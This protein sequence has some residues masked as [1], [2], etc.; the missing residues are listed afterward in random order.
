M[1]S[2]HPLLRKLQFLESDLTWGVFLVSFDEEDT[3]RSDL[4]PKTDEEE[5]Q[6]RPVS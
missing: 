3:P 6:V 5:T 2:L 4:N 1:A